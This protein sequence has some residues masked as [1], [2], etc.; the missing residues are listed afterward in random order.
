MEGKALGRWVDPGESPGPAGLPL[1]AATGL[2]VKL[3]AGVGTLHALMISKQA[4]PV[5]VAI[6]TPIRSI[7]ASRGSPWRVRFGRAVHPQ[8]ARVFPIAVASKPSTARD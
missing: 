4:N 2:D 6:R 3:S 8:D 5:A 7:M 1:G